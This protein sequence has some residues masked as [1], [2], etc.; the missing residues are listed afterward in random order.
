M[1]FSMAMW[2]QDLYQDGFDAE[3]PFNQLLYQLFRYLALLFSLPVLVL[4]GEPV[5]AGVAESLR[6]RTLSVDLLVLLGVGA[7]TIYSAVSVLRGTGHV[8]F[9]VACL[10]LVLLT[11]GR[12]LEATG[13]QRTSA[14]L[15]ALEKLLPVSVRCLADDGTLRWIDRDQVQVGD[16]LQVLP[17]ERIAVDGKVLTGS[18]EVDEQVITGEALPHVKDPGDRVYSGSLNLSGDLRI[19]ATSVAG[20]DTLAR[21]L[22]LVREAR[23]KQGSYA[24]LAD[25]LAGG[26]VPVMFLIAL[27][28]GVWHGRAESFDT[29]VL[30]G[31]AVALIACPCALGLATPMAVWA[32]M[33]RGAEQGVLFGS[34]EALERLAT[35]RA[36]RFDK[37]GT[38][39]TG[40][41]TVVRWVWDEPTGREAVA[42]RALAAAE[43]TS[44]PFAQAIGRIL[45]TEVP[46]LSRL[47]VETSQTLPGQGVR[48]Q[49]AAAAPE[50]LLGS[51]EF[52]RHR[53]LRM[54]APLQAVLDNDRARRLSRVCVGWQG[55]V[56]GVF[57]LAEALRP[58]VEEALDACR[59]LGIDLEILTGD[60]SDR[61]AAIAEQLGVAV[62]AE[63]LP[64]GK[65]DA[66]EAARA[67]F[68]V[69]GM[70]GD[71]V[72][73]APAM[74]A[75]DLGVALGCGADLARDTA[76]VCLLTDDLMRLPWAIGLAR[77]TLRTVRQNLAWAFGYNLIGVALAATGHLNPVWAA[78]AMALSSLLVVNNSL[79]LNYFASASAGVPTAGDTTAGADPAE[80]GPA[81]VV[82]GGGS[83]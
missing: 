13:K 80:R 34:G 39:T 46:R 31:L 43:A 23:L 22:G 30:A 33:G 14:S 51:Q 60:H 5:L 8:Y 35:V 45:G 21:L 37:T 81:L 57:L 59:Q 26:F 42:S 70:V 18:S 17:G 24:R 41:A 55:R 3:D 49:L 75:S 58:S 65:V 66:L 7:A 56:R 53:G 25:R 76:D 69:V 52:L 64:A 44:H 72:N 48:A 28:A 2:S 67:S 82:L 16:L 1:V 77:Q 19:E 4:L 62:Q 68:Q 63:L 29:G 74:A 54:P 47:S 6:R 79:R 12:W 32:A 9:E 61:G 50:V 71:G 11:L 73:D 40:Q 27:G 83:R 20:D 78:L 15:D 36:L 10:V 38:L